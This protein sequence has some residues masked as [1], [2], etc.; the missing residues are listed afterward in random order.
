SLVVL[1]VIAAAATG[2]WWLLVA[3]PVAGYA[4]AW[5]SHFAVERNRPATFAHPL[6]SLRADFRMWLLWLTG[7]L[8]RELEAADREARGDR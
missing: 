6:W 5:A 1:L 8:V 7:R 4:F 2:S 3:V